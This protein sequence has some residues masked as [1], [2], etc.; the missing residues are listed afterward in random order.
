[1]LNSERLLVMNAIQFEHKVHDYFEHLKA[2]WA[3]TLILAIIFIALLC[4]VLSSPV[5]HG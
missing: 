3:E 2:N 1:M 4:L 5:S